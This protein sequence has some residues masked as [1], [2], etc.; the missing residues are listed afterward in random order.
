[1]FGNNNCKEVVEN[2]CP[3]CNEHLLMNK[4]SFANHVRWCKCNPK[5]N[6]M[7]RSTKSKISEKSIKQHI[8]RYGKYKEYKVYCNTCGKEIIV[9]E[10]ENKFDKNKKY[11]CS[12]SCANTHKLNDEQKHHIS[13]GIRQYLLNK[14]QNYIF[15]KDKIKI[16]PVCGK[17]FNSKGNTCSSSCGA[18]YKL[19]KRIPDI[20]SKENNEKLKEIKSIYKRYCQFQFSLNDFPDE[21]DFDLINK[22]G[23]YK[24]RNRGNNLNGISRDHKYSC[25]EAFNNLIDPY[26]ISH[27]ANCQLLIHNDNISKLDK[28]SLTIDELKNRILKWNNK[29]GNYPNKIDYNLFD[30]LGINFYIKL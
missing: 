11:Y 5:R 9:K 26:I 8:Q 27:P 16:C 17:Q 13:Q 30:K 2:V 25:N 21:F 14:D 10:R 18:K 6:E 1:M 22:Y 12:K 20:L 28:C 23:W 24:A 3:Y 15:S 19:Y 7:L 4:R 29:Y